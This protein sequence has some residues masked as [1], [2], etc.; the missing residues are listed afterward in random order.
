M[1]KGVEKWLKEEIIGFN[2]NGGQLSLSFLF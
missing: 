2:G 1:V